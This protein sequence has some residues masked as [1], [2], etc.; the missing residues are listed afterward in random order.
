MNGKVSFEATRYRCVLHFNLQYFHSGEDFIGIGPGFIGL[1]RFAG[2]R[3]LKWEAGFITEVGHG[4][5]DH[6]VRLALE[7]EPNVQ[8]DYDFALS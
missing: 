1:H 3:Q 2:Q 8:P 5:K 4:G 6:S 7:F